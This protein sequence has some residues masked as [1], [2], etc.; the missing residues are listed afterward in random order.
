M[1]S[2]IGEAIIIGIA[3]IFAA[4]IAAGRYVP[5]AMSKG[6]LYLSDRLTGEVWFCSPR[7]CKVISVKA[8]VSEK[9]AIPPMPPGYSNVPPPPPG[10]TVDKPSQR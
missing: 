5:T 4:A 7:D 10:F 2:R 9:E 6:G 1:K 8:P 3:I